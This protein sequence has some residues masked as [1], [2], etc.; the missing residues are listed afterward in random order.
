LQ[1]D[2]ADVHAEISSQNMLDLPQ[3]NRTYLGLLEIVP[4]VTPPG[5]QLSGGTNNPFKG[6]SYSFNGG[7]LMAQ[8]IRIEGINALMPWGAATARTMCPPPKPSRT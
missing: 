3:P 4:G 7:G 5:G 8:T 1:T 2:R 6:M